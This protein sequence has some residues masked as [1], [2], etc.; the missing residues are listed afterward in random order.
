VLDALEQLNLEHFL[1]RLHDI[2]RSIAEFVWESMVDLGTGEEE[3]FYVN[4]ISSVIDIQEEGEA[5]FGD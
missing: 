5:D 2:H 1:L 4:A 3:R